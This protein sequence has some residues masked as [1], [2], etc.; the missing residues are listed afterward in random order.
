MTP[1]EAALVA[2]AGAMVAANWAD[3]N[4]WAPPAIA[5]TLR[6]LWGHRPGRQQSQLLQQLVDDSGKLRATVKRIETSLH[7]TNRTV[8]VLLKLQRLQEEGLGLATFLT[9]E[10][11]RCIYANQHYLKLVGASNEDVLDSGW[12]NIIPQEMQ[13]EVLGS[14]EHSVRDH[15]DFRLQYS[16]CHLTTGTRIP[17][18]CVAH[19]VCD[20]H[21]GDVIGWIGHVKP[22]ADRQSDH[23]HPDLSDTSAD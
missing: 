11:G 5:K 17:V 18:S 22:L 3:R 16:M 10:Q 4:Q 12:K 9:D 6:W 14:W 13:S 7:G 23:P 1:I 8:Q 21:S 15:R 2:L 19:I 20:E